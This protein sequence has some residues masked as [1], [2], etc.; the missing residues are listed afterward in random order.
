MEIIFIMELIML[1]KANKEGIYAYINGQSVN[2]NPYDLMGGM[3]VI[4]TNG[5]MDFLMQKK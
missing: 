4:I 1:T 3:G 2:D 5:K